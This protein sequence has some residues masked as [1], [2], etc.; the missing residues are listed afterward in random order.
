MDQK[1]DKTSGGKRSKMILFIV[2][3]VLVSVLVTVA[4][5]SWNVRQPERPQEPKQPYPY[6]SEDV[7]F[8]NPAADVILS[9]TLTL[10][11]E[12]GTY[13]AVILISGSGPQTRDYNFAG[14]N[15]FL[16]LADYLTRNGIAVLRY[17]DRGFG[18][19]TG[20]FGL[21]TSLDFS[22]DV[23][24]AIDFLKTRKEIRKDNIGLIGHSDGAMI[25]PMVA[26]RRA[27]VDFIV[28][29]AGPGINGAELLLNRQEI[30]ERKMGLTETQIKKSRE[31]SS[32]LIEIV[33]NAEN[34]E[35]AKDHLTQFSKQNYDDIPA[36]A[37]PPGM[38][39]DEFIGKHID[40]LSAPWFK[41]FFT[42][43]PAPILA[44][45]VCPVLALNGDMDVQVPAK[46]NL[47]AIRIALEAGGNKDATVHEVVGIN[48]AFQ[49]CETG[50][51]DE[52]ARIE[53]TFSPAVMS[54]IQKWITGQVK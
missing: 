22:Y 11:S 49:E 38:T 9:G 21:G 28:L 1:I 50:M 5:I 18:K 15:S 31:H 12:Q 53:Q 51:V 3:G 47:E 13:P 40:M 19:S 25:A 33:V 36:Y 30:L 27:D 48:H 32:R 14:H 17:D 35:V 2:A 44:Q 34:S 16:V 4:I 10:P 45:V 42:Y 37:V 43:D 6:Y 29:L 20:N 41:Y 8:I 46:E 54:E 24:S 26:A 52:Y 7:T 39:K 23:E